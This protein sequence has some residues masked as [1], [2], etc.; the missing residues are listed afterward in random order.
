MSRARVAV[1][2]VISRQLSVTAAAAEYGYSRQHLHRL[3]ARYK[4]GLEAVEAR[5][6]RPLSNPRATEGKVRDFIVKTR[7]ELTAA[8][9][10]AGPVTIAWHLEQAG[11]HVPS[12]ST[13]RRILHAAGLVAPEP[14]K[15]PRS[16]C[17]RFAAAQ[18]NECWQSDFTR[19]ALAGGGDAEII[20]WLEATPATC[21]PPGPRSPARSSSTHSCRPATPTGSPHQPSLI[22]N[23]RVC[24]ARFGSGRNAFECLLGAL[25]ITQKNG[26]PFHPQT[27]GKGERFHQ[28]Q[29]RWLAGSR[30]PRPWRTCSSSSTSSAST[31][32]STAPTGQ[33]TALSPARPTGHGPRPDPAAPRTI[34]TGR[35]C[36]A[37]RPGRG[38]RNPP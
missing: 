31:T 38:R 1:L 7:L 34:T 21:S 20:N 19:W 27:Q 29:K 4:A 5:S 37:A 16:S 28:T 33:C 9:W 8:G 6:R 3:V 17:L 23:G 35:R 11:L 2:K 14:R 32:T 13:T 18:P 26:Q 36:A 10:D 30:P 12:A 24:T 15:R 25:G 22:F